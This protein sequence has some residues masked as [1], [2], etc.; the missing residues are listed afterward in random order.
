MRFVF[1]IVW[2]CFLLFRLC[3]V[4]GCFFMTFGM[5]NVKVVTRLFND[6][7]QFKYNL[8]YEINIS[9]TKSALDQQVSNMKKKMMDL[10][11]SFLC[12]TSEKQQFTWEDSRSV[13]IML[14]FMKLKFYFCN[15]DYIY[16]VRIYIVDVGW[17]INF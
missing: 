5:N 15:E 12:C 1:T 6:I 17:L 7:R 9:F 4:Y 3:V 8:S 11:I 2:K 14:D 13:C 10:W 16:F